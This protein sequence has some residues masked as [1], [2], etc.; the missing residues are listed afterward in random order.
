VAALV[1]A[2]PP[3]LPAQLATLSPLAGITSLRTPVYIVADRQDTYIPNAESLK[4][5]DAQPALVH[6]SYVSLL[7]HV[8]PMVQAQSNALATAW[9]LATGAWQLFLAIDHTL[10]ALQ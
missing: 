2:L 1:A 4:L 8:E 3:P 6:L 7:A 9:D 10:A 5:R